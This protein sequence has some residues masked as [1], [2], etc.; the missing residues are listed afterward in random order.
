M[1]DMAFEAAVLT[2]WVTA[3]DRYL[4]NLEPE[5]R[6][7]FKEATPQNLYNASNIEREDRVKSK[8][9]NAMAAIQ[10]LVEKIEEYGK[11]MDT[12]ANAA[13][14]I[15]APLWGSLRVILVL[16]RSFTRFYERMTDTLG[17][18]GDIL[19]RLFVSD[20]PPNKEDT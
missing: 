13:P 4:A 11:A 6:I 19:P 14:E 12:F 20:L 15:L 7:L 2:P 17:R 10:P 18:I 3:R 9:R 16:A 5:E 1:S 8:T